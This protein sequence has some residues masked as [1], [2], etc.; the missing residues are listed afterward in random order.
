MP[1][2]RLSELI[3][4]GRSLMPAQPEWQMSA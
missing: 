2:D 3:E 4:A 1:A